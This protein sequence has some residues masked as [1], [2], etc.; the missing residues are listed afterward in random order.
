MT[1]VTTFRTWNYGEPLLGYH[2][3]YESA[4]TPLALGMFPSSIQ[5]LNTGQSA[6]V[7]AS[8]HMRRVTFDNFLVFYHS[9][10][11]GLNQG[12]TGVAMPLSIKG[13]VV[14]YRSYIQ[15]ISSNHPSVNSSN[16]NIAILI[17]NIMQS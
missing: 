7:Q 6:L 3:Q 11:D 9:E 16:V 10:T 17:L 4:T 1:L 13:R 12:V 5:R 8:Y 2:V 14:N 15:L